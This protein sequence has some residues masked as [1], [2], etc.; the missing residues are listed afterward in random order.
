MSNTFTANIGTQIGNETKKK[1][2]PRNKTSTFGITINP[3][4]KTFPSEEKH[5]IVHDCLLKIAT[6]IFGSENNFKNYVRFR[7]EGESWT[8][9]FITKVEDNNIT[10]EY[11]SKNYWH[12]QGAIHIK[13]RSNILL[14]IDEFKKKTVKELND[15]L[16]PLNIIGTLLTPS[17]I[18]VHIQT[19]YGNKY[20][21][22][23]IQRAIDY[24]LKDRA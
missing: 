8:P 3:S 12:I 2:A 4:I 19:G 1:R 13:H 16:I 18:Y 24:P 17:N 20:I 14:N 5:K 7:K 23:D 22:E 6:D 10:I 9:E 15:C 21:S 11:S